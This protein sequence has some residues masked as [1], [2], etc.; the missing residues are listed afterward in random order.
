VDSKRNRHII[1]YS[2]CLFI[3][4]TASL[5]LV[6]LSFTSYK[7]STQCNVDGA[8]PERKKMLCSEILNAINCKL[9][10]YSPT[11]YAAQIKVTSRETI[12]LKLQCGW[13]LNLSQNRLLYYTIVCLLCIYSHY[14]ISHKQTKKI[15]Q[16][17]F[18]NVIITV[19]L[20]YNAIFDSIRT[21][22]SLNSNSTQCSNTGLVNIKDD[23]VVIL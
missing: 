8:S 6:I 11:Y 10:F 1:F 23:M 9:T 4:Q 12:D 20:L 19:C 14:V 17:I 15:K 21:S 2:I 13:P 7:D 16:L 18:A 22:N 5:L 3:T